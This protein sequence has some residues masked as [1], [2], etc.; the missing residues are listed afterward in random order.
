MN[1]DDLTSA[2]EC[3]STTQ[4]VKGLVSILRN[5]KRNDEN[6]VTLEKSVERYIGHVWFESDLVHNKIYSLW[7]R[8]RDEAIHSSGGMTM[9][10]RLHR[11][12]LFERFDGAGQLDQDAIYAKVCASR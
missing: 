12:G 3:I 7:T 6:V 4:D 1:I 11:F 10:E 2:I 9:N 8:F 5:W